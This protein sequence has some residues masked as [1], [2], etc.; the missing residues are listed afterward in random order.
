MRGKLAKAIRR[1]IGFMACD[2]RQ[3]DMGNAKSKVAVSIDGKRSLYDVTGTIKSTGKR[4]DYQIVKR[5]GIYKH[6]LGASK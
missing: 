1:A 3:Y 2:Q 5:T 6:I 4:R